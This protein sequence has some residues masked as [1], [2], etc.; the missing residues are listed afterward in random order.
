MMKYELQESMKSVAHME[1]L[2]HD[3]RITHG[4]IEQQVQ[5][6]YMLQAVTAVIL[7]ANFMKNR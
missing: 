2:L 3:L 6:P 4:E 1:M 5:N 7:P